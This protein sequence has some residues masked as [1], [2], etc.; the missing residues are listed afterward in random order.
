[1]A[2]SL[3]E[4]EEITAN[5]EQQQFYKD[6]LIEYYKLGKYDN[7]D[8]NNLHGFHTFKNAVKS[9]CLDMSSFNWTEEHKNRH[10]TNVYQGFVNNYLNPETI[11]ELET[12]VKQ[13]QQK[14]FE[15]KVLAEADEIQKKIQKKIQ[16][17]LNKQNETTKEVKM[18]NV[19]LKIINN[20]LSY[21]I[22]SKNI[23]LNIKRLKKYQQK[24]Q[25][26]NT[27]NL[28]KQVD[29]LY[30][31]R[32]IPQFQ[33]AENISIKL[34]NAKTEKQ[35]ILSKNKAEALIQKYEQQK[36]LGERLLDKTVEISHTK[37]DKPLSHIELKITRKSFHNM[38]IQEVFAKVKKQVVKNVEKQWRR[39]LT[40]SYL[41]E[42]TR[43]SF[44]MSLIL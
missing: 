23:L 32:K 9:V 30:E 39:N 3:R 41:W 19:S 28:L 36:P 1:M 11:R 24:T 18:E 37:T 42:L 35:K 27:L 26:E 38:T 6:V 4:L 43:C 16:R 21:N 2:E 5:T 10:L 15:Q 17:K 25:N 44:I 29:K 40:L 7:L 33:T 31:E 8:I 34:V 14:E 20:N 12:K 22:M 13:Q